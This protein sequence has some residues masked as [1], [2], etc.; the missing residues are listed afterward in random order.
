MF[1]NFDQNNSGGSFDFDANMGITHHVIVEAD[2]PS[3]ANERA[4]SIGVYF[5]DTYEVDCECCGSRWTS[6]WDGDT[7]SEHPEVYGDPVETYTPLINWMGEDPE[8]FVHYADGRV[9]AFL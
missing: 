8:V 3:E 5:D 6:L 7:G 2:N 4:E 1:Y 9:E